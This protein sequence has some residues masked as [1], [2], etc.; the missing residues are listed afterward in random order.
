MFIGLLTGLI[1]SFNHTKYVSLTNQKCEIQPTVVNLHPN[2]CT[3]G[4]CY[5]LFVVN[6][7]RCIRSCNTLNDLSNEVCAPNKTEVWLQEKMN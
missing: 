3:S 5:Y 7:D 6:L 2:E 1:I 4:L